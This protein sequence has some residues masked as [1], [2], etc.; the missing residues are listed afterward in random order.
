[1][2]NTIDV[3][4]ELQTK[5][6]EAS[7]KKFRT[8]ID[9]ITGRVTKF[10][11]Q[12]D[13]SLGKFDNNIRKSTKNVKNFGNVSN[14]VFSSFIGNLGAIATVNAFAFI[15][16]GASEAISQLVELD[17]ALAEIKTIMPLTDR[18]AQKLTNT[19]R[20]FSS[21]FGT[22]PATQAKSFY[23]IVSA[24]ITDV[25]EATDV[26]DA[27]NKLALG[28]LADLETTITAVT[29]VISVYGKEAGTT[30]DITD[31]LFKAVELGQTKVE[32]LASALPQVLSLS[33]TLGVSFKDLSAATAT[34]TTR[35]GSTSIAVTQLRALFS[36]LIRNQET[37]TKVLGKN[38]TAF[39]LASLRTK[40][41]T[42]F[43]KDLTKETGNSARL[44]K[45]L[46]GRVE[47]L[48]AVLNL[49]ADGFVKLASNTQKMGEA[50]GATARA[51]NEMKESLDIQSDIFVAQMTNAATTLLEILKPALI[52]TLKLLNELFSPVKIPGL[53]L[54]ERVS[55][56]GKAIKGLEGQLQRL[57]ADESFL[58]KL[59]GTRAKIEERIT[60]FKAQQD[61][62]FDEASK[63]TGAGSSGSTPEDLAAINRAKIQADELIKIEQA[64]NTT[65]AAIAAD[66]DLQTEE[67]EN[68]RTATE[69]IFSDD[70]LNRLSQVLGDE[71]T[72]RLQA[73]VLRLESQN[74]FTE[75]RKKLETAEIAAQVIAR[76][77]NDKVQNEIA[78]SKKK[79]QATELKDQAAFFS[80]A[81]SLASSENKALALIGKTAA[82]TEIAIKTPQAVASSFAFGTRIGGP[83]VGFA[84]GAIAATAMAAQAAQVAGIQG[85]ADG[86]VVGGFQG[87]T[88][89]PD[90]EVITARRGEMFLNATQQRN[91][92]NQIDSG[93][94]SDGEMI[95]AINNLA[96]RPVVLEIDGREIA[97]TVKEQGL[98]GFSFA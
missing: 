59:V 76:K 7:A 19:F 24:G 52:G 1:M 27:S 4:L 15:S 29:K 36:S 5:R 63:K 42:E 39:S 97:R 98:Q 77:N 32:D 60:F 6:A 48:N 50:A 88:G 65:L 84:L 64:K 30:T 79:R 46:G 2:A 10:G 91:L 20:E 21:T 17:A 44:Q 75:A 55:R 96:S 49:G 14:G 57:D 67:R 81:T 56:V 74:K 22:D 38:S 3:L 53:S 68:I 80:A 93:G 62:L 31:T 23:Q 95:D 40:G 45:V 70:R 94:N 92:F 51:T 18:E 87:S 33:R 41:L 69:Q 47:S 89:G 8:E 11:T 9:V 72:I 78:K 13:A 61:K 90:N 86:G 34:L 37:A 16:R 82:L 43:L 25:A 83:P 58:D 26:L 85:F 35:T 12:S 54:T 66:Q 71:A 28:G 73:E